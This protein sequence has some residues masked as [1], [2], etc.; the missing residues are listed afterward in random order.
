MTELYFIKYLVLY[1]STTLSSASRRHATTMFRYFPPKASQILTR[2]HQQKLHIQSHLR[3]SDGSWEAYNSGR[4]ACLAS[5]L[6]NSQNNPAACKGLQQKSHRLKDRLDIVNVCPWEERKSKASLVYLSQ[7]LMANI[8]NKTVSLLA[9]IIVGCHARFWL[10]FYQVYPTITFNDS[11]K[12]PRY[13]H[14]SPRLVWS[15]RKASPCH[16]RLPYW[17]S[18][19]VCC[20]MLA[21]KNILICHLPF[22]F[23]VV[24]E[25]IRRQRQKWEHLPC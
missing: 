15:S 10:Q 7:Q 13:L 24:A 8:E 22:L 1:L 2:R 12:Q 21:F 23:V 18:H 3:P 4:C 19:A 17:V 6:W 16:M 25:T 5:H 20:G 9:L 11:F 14:Q